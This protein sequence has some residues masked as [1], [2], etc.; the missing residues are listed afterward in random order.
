MLQNKNKLE[1]VKNKF[2]EIRIAKAALD[3]SL[4]SEER[5]I[6]N[7]INEIYENENKCN[8]LKAEIKT[9]EENIVILNNGIAERGVNVQKINSRISSLE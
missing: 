7:K 1:D 4:Q 5:Q 6:K 3:E 8:S 2:T 9:K